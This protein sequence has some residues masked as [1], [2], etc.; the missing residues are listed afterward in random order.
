MTAAL[1]RAV[2]APHRFSTLRTVEETREQ[3][4][5]FV[6]P[7]S[8]STIKFQLLLHSRPERSIYNR[9]LFAPI[10]YAFMANLTYI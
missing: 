7:H 9:R 8:R 3:R 5:H 6:M 10:G 1:P 4:V 2:C